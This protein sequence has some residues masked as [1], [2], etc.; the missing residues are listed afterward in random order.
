MGALAIELE[1]AAVDVR[2]GRAAPLAPRLA[3]LATHVTEPTTRFR[4]LGLL[5][6]AALQG[7]QVSEAAAAEALRETLAHDDSERS[8]IRLRRVGLAVLQ[9]ELALADE[10]AAPLLAGADSRIADEARLRLIA[11]RSMRDLRAWVAEDKPRVA[12]DARRAGLAALRLLGDA[13]AAERHLVAAEHSGQGDPSLYEALVEV[14]SRLDRPR[15]L[16]RTTRSLIQRS[17]DEREL[18]QLQLALANALSATGDLRG[19][20][21][22]LEPLERIADLRIR[23][24]ARRAR[25]E[26]CRR[27]GKLDAAVASIRDPIER[28]FIALEVEGDYQ[29]AER[30]YRAASAAH[31]DSF[32]AAAGV[33]EAGRRRE[34]AE[35]S[36]LYQQVLAKEP[37]DDATRSK[38]VATLAALGDA[39]GAERVVVAAIGGGA[40]SSE[41][42]LVAALTLGRAGLT[43]EAARY[44][45]KAYA[46][47]KAPA[48][49]QQILFAVGDLYASARRRESARRL[50]TS[51][52]TDGVSPEIRERALARLAS[53]TP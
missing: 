10:L 15:E 18:P 2:L 45:E 21:A 42:L 23:L 47:E 28:A 16:A 1:H 51:L 4:I 14:Y 22:A 41:Q 9:G 49:Q 29:K 31:P 25:Y 30:L 32:E 39:E 50:F 33:Q 26:A 11:A 6:D 46:A 13:E 43:L 17:R 20:L 53:L 27:A 44:L 36:G 35:R 3:A 48:K 52:A 34:L 5:A 38:L 24:A 12:E 37:H 8:S 7:D 40:P 19:A